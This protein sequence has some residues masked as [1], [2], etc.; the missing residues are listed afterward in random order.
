MTNNNLPT[1]LDA[2]PQ[3]DP[4]RE[5]LEAIAVQSGNGHELGVPVMWCKQDADKERTRDGEVPLTDDQW[6]E[7]AFELW[8]ADLFDWD[9]QVLS[10]CISEVL[11]DEQENDQ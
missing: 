2:V 6:S 7:V 4:N 11:D 9:W 10:K 8:N 5:L 1:W 3:D